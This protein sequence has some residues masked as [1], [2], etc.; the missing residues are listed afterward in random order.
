[1]AKRDYYE[2]LGVERNATKN[3]IK[4]AYKK[5]ARKFHPDVAENKE[6]AEVKFREINEAY[7]VLGDDEK[8]AGYDRFGHAGVSSA[9]G[10]GYGGFPFDS[11]FGG[12]GGGGFEDIFDAF[13]DMGGLGGRRGRS[14][15]RAV[16]GRDVR[17]DVE[18]KLEDAFNGLETNVEVETD[19]NCP[20]CDGRRVKPGAG[21]KQCHV[22]HGQGA[23]RNVQN[24]VFGQFVTSTTCHKCNGTGQ[25]PEEVCEECNGTGRTRNKRKITVNIPKGIDN[26]QRIRIPDEGEAG[27]FGGPNGDLY[28]FVFI[29][30]HDIFERRGADLFTELPIGFADAALGAEKEISTFDGPQKVKIKEGAQSETVIKLKGLGMPELQGK[31]RGDLHVKVKVITPTKLSKKQRDLLCQF[32]DEGPQFHC[33]KKSFFGKILDAITGK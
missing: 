20:V 3:E 1:M 10:G 29:K 12:F 32:A 30:E 31:R 18:I 5:L 22:C 11:G 4:M 21:F 33:E 13:F 2:I 24:T 19:Q 25:I 17:K 26:G 7:S 28:I 27:Q 23:V 16:R 9:A 6:E 14:R 8:K 15:T